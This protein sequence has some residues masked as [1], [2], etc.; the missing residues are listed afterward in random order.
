VLI[1]GSN[2]NNSVQVGS[3]YVNANNDSTNLNSNIGSQLSLLCKRFCSARTMP[4]GKTQSNASTV[5]VDKN[6]RLRGEISR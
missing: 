2:S 4:L 1:V 5:L 6:R 3:F